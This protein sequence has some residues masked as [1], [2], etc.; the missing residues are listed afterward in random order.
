MYQGGKSSRPG[1]T[2]G[3]LHC[4]LWAGDYGSQ[5][6]MQVT[7]SQQSSRDVWLSAWGKEGE[8]GKESLALCLEEWEEFHQTPKWDG[9]KKVNF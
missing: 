7:E 6:N 5:S 3:S 9:A 4:S 1:E 2:T 8:K